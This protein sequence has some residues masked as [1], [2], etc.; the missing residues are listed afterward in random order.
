MNTN[1]KM[2]LLLEQDGNVTIES[3]LW[4]PLYFV[5][6]MLAV[7]TTSLMAN[8]TRMWTVASDSS[9]LVALGVLSEAE[10][11]E[12]AKLQAGSLDYN[13]TVSKNASTVTTDITMLF[14]EAA[15]TG[16]LTS[17]DSS[18]SVSSTY[19]IEPSS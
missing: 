14:N 17:L 10:A 13:V 3:V 1:I 7:D 16:F 5:L 8:E 4:L 19:R 2:P 6:F 11:E 18:L 9:R 12:H 15:G